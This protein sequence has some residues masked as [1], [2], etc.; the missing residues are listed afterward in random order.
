[1]AEDARFE[2]GG[3]RPLRLMAADQE[4]LSVVSALIQDA[5]FP[6]TEMKWQRRQRRFVILLNR[7]RWEDRVEA[8]SR[9]RGYERTQSLLIIDDSLRVAT[10]GLDL[11]DRDT[12]LSVLSLGFEPGED[13][14]GRLLL[15]LAGDGA[16]A[17]DVEAINVTL[18]DVT[19]PYLAP[20]GKAPAHPD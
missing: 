7:F 1:M 15:T 10:Q 2:E 18:R 17:I 8:E 13:G 11:T 19:R 9:G 16:V 5:V 12:V 14:T 4:D 3:E 6:L 20:S